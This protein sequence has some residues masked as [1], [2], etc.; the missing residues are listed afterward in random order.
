ML[1]P[2]MSTSPADAPS[3]ARLAWPFFAAT[4]AITWLLQLPAVLVV[5]G[6]LPGPVER[7]MAPMGLGAFGPLLG[8]LLVARWGRGGGGV[9]A[10]FRPLRTWPGVTW[11]LVALGLSGAIFVAAK[12]VYTLAGGHDPGPWF[13]PPL[14]PPR[15]VALFV[16]PFGEELGWRGFAQPRLQ[17]RHGVLTASLLVG[18]LWGLWHIPMFL[19]AGLS[20]GAYAL[21]LPFFLAGSVVFGWL[22]GRTRAGLWLAILA[23]VGAHLS[24]THQALPGHV[25]PFALHTAGYVVVALGLVLIDRRTFRSGA[26]SD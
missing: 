8:A 18:L 11:P 20:L 10:L 3:S 24:N 7:F 25:T 17:A 4:F 19:V 16:F 15:I 22:Y 21:A 12:A 14:D 6:R 2:P 9:R 23:H 26:R 1:A 5:L 13:Y